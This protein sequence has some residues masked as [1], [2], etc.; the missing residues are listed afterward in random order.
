MR[1]RFV[2]FPLPFF[3]SL[4]FSVEFTTMFYFEDG[5]LWRL[6]IVG[7]FPIFSKVENH[8]ERFLWDAVEVKFRQFSSFF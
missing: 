8:F 3:F 7:F 5:T 2:M 4:H 1:P 6:K